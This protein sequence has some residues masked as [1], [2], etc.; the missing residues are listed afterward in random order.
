MLTFLRLIV[1]LAKFHKYIGAAM[2]L[3]QYIGATFPVAPDALVQTHGL[4]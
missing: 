3:A 1:Q 2:H 4:K